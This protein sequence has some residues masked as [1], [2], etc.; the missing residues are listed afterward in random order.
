MGTIEREQFNNLLVDSAAEV[1]VLQPKAVPRTCYTDQTKVIAGVTGHPTPCP[2]AKVVITVRGYQAQVEAVVA[3]L[4]EDMLLGRDLPFFNDFLTN[5]ARQQRGNEVFS[6]S[7]RSQTRAAAHNEAVAA[8]SGA[9]P[10]PLEDK[11]RATP[12]SQED[13]NGAIPTSLEDENGATPTSLEDENGATPTFLDETE[14]GLDLL[15][16]SLFSIPNPPKPRLT[17]NQKRY[18]ARERQTPAEYPT[19][20]PVENLGK[21]QREDESL[22][23][24]RKQAELDPNSSYT[25]HDGV[26]YHTSL[27]PHGDSL[28]QVVVPQKRRT[29]LLKSARHSPL[30]GH[31]GRKKTEAKLLRDF[32]WPGLGRDVGTMCAQCPECQKGNKNKKQRAPLVPLPVIDES[33]RRIAMDIVSPLKR[34]TSGHKYI[35]TVMDYATHYPEAI[36]LKNTDAK[37]VA[38]ALCQVFSRLGLPE[39]VL[40]DQGTNFMSDLM[41]MVFQLLSIKH[42]KTSPYHPQTNGMIER[43]HAT[44]KSMIRKLCTQP[45]EW[46][47]WLPY[48]CFAFRDSPH[49]A[50]GFSPFELLFGRNVRGPLTLLKEQWTAKSHTPQ[51]FVNSLQERLQETAELARKNEERAKRKEKSWYD[52]KA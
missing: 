46:D 18:Q 4:G 35:L 9:T 49:T 40:S 5:V 38:E 21:E 15:D 36:P 2:T 20:T 12:T 41:K 1:T 48:V 8:T 23:E 37:T 25:I 30:A 47:K 24:L 44:L 26:L 28:L 11:S 51:S 27:S 42:L 10:T 13:E 7:T 29:E 39:E 6:V 14:P 43:F 3:Q 34:T 50:T 16:D 52:A 19:A 45:K 32:F 33:F 22:K 17:R 31:L